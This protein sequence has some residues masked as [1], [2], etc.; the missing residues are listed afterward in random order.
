MPSQA[1][2]TTQTPH[3]F[4]LSRPVALGP[5]PELCVLTTDLSSASTLQDGG[6]ESRGQ[7]PSHPPLPSH[8]EPP[9]HHPVLSEEM[10]TGGTMEPGSERATASETQGHPH[11]F[12]L[13]TNAQN[14]GDPP[15]RQVTP[16]LRH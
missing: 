16:E 8:L 9:A 12:G 1:T 10:F 3:P 11:S 13:G 14:S 7:Y 4:Q 15:A 5:A 2:P 6:Q